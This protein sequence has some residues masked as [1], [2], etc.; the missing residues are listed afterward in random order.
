MTNTTPDELLRQR[1]RL[2]LSLAAK[3]LIEYSFGLLATFGEEGIAPVSDVLMARRLL[4]LAHRYR[5]LAVLCAII[6]RGASWNDVAAADG[7]SMPDMFGMYG[8]AVERWVQG[9]PAP[10]TPQIASVQPLLFDAAP[11]HINAR[12]I[13]KL[14][15]ALDEFYAQYTRDRIGGDVADAVS[16]GLARVGRQGP[17]WTSAS[18]S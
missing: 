6:V 12:N 16:G 3:D 9:D 11:I 7:R 14:S 5:T 18:S 10:W 2:A 15:K 4:T 8:D 17:P 1:T 13:T